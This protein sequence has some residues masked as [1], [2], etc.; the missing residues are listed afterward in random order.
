MDRKPEETNIFLIGY[1]CTGKTSVGMRLAELTGKRFV[2]A[3][4]WFTARHGIISEYVAAY[5]WDEFR[6]QETAI[7]KTIAR[8]GD[9][10][11]ATGGGVVLKSENVAVMKARGLVV[12]L[13]A[14]EET[15][16]RRMAA[17]PVTAVSRP[18]LTALPLRDEIAKTLAE[19]MPLYRRAMDF[20]VDTDGLPV[21]DVCRRIIDEV[22]GKG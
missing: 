16:A 17:D 3:D 19:R 14:S 7:L 4:D 15:I 10:V 12:W 2:D 9:Q 21:E 5:G 8:G 18:G 6:R 11:I 22:A 20:C 13:T 1:R